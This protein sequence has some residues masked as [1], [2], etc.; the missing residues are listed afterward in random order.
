V[1]ADFT[2]RKVYSYFTLADDWDGK[3]DSKIIF[4]DPT[5]NT[6]SLPFWIPG[7][8]FH[9]KLPLREGYDYS[10]NKIKD[11]GPDPEFPDNGHPE[12]LDAFGFIKDDRYKYIDRLNA[13]SKFPL[14]QREWSIDLRTQDEGL[15]IILHASGMP[16]FFLGAGDV[17]LGYNPTNKDGAPVSNDI[18]PDGEGTYTLIDAD[19]QTWGRQFYT[20]KIDY[21]DLQFTLFLIG[22]AYAEGQWPATDPATSGDQFEVKVINIPNARKDRVLPDTV[23]LLDPEGQL[24]KSNGGL[25]RDDTQMLQ[26]VAKVAFQW[27]NTPRKAYDVTLKNIVPQVQLGQLITNSNGRTLNSVVTQI[28]IDLKRNSHTIKTQ[29]AEL[30]GTFFSPEPRKLLGKHR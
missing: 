4:P 22:D 2:L 30:D 26:D 20:Q 23:V 1:R 18:G 25:V 29:F 7:L 24:V 19:C 16:Q 15:G 21:H 12:Y 14:Y 10:K 8:R 11:D 6:K 9:H 27:F 17:K 28:V 13:P 5:D 3:V